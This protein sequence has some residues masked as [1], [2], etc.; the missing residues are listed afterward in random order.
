MSRFSTGDLVVANGVVAQNLGAPGAIS[1]VNEGSVVLLKSIANANEICEVG[2]QGLNGNGT[3]I[4]L[5]PENTSSPKWNSGF[6]IVIVLDTVTQVNQALSL[7]SNVFIPYGSAVTATADATL[8]VSP[9]WGAAAN[10]DSQYTALANTSGGNVVYTLPLSSTCVGYAIRFVKTDA[11]ANFL[12]VAVLTGDFIQG[13]AGPAIWGDATA[14]T[15]YTLQAFNNGW[16]QVSG[17]PI[18]AFIPD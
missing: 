4:T 11:G 5:I 17:L 3:Y 15:Y 2:E 13:I 9:V 12:N 1:A 16:R 18:A 6:G 10:P 7:A 14:N 8:E